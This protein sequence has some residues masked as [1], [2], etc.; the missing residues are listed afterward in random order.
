MVIA[1]KLKLGHSITRLLGES[2]RKREQVGGGAL[3][4]SLY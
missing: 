4:L 3:N 1:C 2:P